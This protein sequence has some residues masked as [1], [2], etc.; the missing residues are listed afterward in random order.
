M[1]LYILITI[2]IETK[3]SRRGESFPS[4]GNIKKEIQGTYSWVKM[5][6]FP[7]ESLPGQWRLFKPLSPFCLEFRR[8][9]PTHKNIAVNWFPIWQVYRL[10]PSPRHVCQFTWQVWSPRSS[11]GQRE[12]VGW[13]IHNRAKL[14]KHQFGSE[15]GQP[16]M[17]HIKNRHRVH[18]SAGN[19]RSYLSA[20]RERHN[21]AAQG[22]EGA[23]PQK[24]ACWNLPPMLW[25]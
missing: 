23:H 20:L 11:R 21:V 16:R 22:S 18:L 4:K 2:E 6:P 19:M 12:V 10:Q 8:K 5:I 14:L 9:K 3:E 15:K 13:E 7:C 24:H 1:F 25:Y 17:C